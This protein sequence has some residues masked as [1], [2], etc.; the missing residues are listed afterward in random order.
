MLSLD[1]KRLVRE[2]PWRL[3]LKKGD[4]IDA[5]FGVAATNVTRVQHW[6]PATITCIIED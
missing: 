4:R 3:S 1:Q 2:V 5:V 6:M